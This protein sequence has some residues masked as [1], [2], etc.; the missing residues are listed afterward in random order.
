MF[1]FFLQGDLLL[2]ELRGPLIS[3]SP[4]S[5]EEEKP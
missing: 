4:T 3:V 5:E 2:A 1:W